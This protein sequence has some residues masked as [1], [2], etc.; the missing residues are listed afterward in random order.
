MV[1]SPQG[2]L[3]LINEAYCGLWT[4]KLYTYLLYHHFSSQI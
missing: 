4:N 1:H 2:T 3:I